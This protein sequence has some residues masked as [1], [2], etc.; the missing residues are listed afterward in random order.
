MVASVRGGYPINDRFVDDKWVAVLYIQI[1]IDG[2]GVAGLYIQAGRLRVEL[3][4]APT[5]LADVSWLSSQPCRAGLR[6]ADGPP[7]LD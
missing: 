3:S 1:L 5:A 4:A 7:G 2:K 6:L